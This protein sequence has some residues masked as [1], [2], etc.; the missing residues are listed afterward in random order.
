MTIDNWI[1]L[2]LQ[3]P[4]EIGDYLVYNSFQSWPHKI[5]VMHFNGKEFLEIGS[6]GIINEGNFLHLTHWQ[7]LPPPPKQL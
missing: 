1:R 7:P 3:P 4:T 2:D 5:E 6:E